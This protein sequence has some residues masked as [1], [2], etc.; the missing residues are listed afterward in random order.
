MYVVHIVLVKECHCPVYCRTYTISY[1]KFWRI[2]GSRLQ[3][4][5]CWE[6]THSGNQPILFCFENCK[7]VMVKSLISWKLIYSFQTKPINTLLWE[8]PTWGVINSLLVL[9]TL[10]LAVHQKK[11][12]HFF[13]FR[14]IL[15]CNHWSYRLDVCTTGKRKKIS[16]HLRY[17]KFLQICSYS[18]KTGIFDVA[19]YLMYYSMLNA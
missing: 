10:N 11:T 7:V 2:E 15:L 4:F 17:I 13:H 12:G 5:T 9:H 16:F 1:I 3:H 6:S 18:W 19:N 8:V 14:C